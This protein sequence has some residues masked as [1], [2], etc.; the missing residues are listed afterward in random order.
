VYG[1]YAYATH[2]RSHTRVCYAYACMAASRSALSLILLNQS[3]GAQFAIFL[4]FR[5]F[6][7][8]TRPPPTHPPPPTHSQTVTP[9]PSSLLCLLLSLLLLLLGHL[10]PVCRRPSHFVVWLTLPPNPNLPPN[11]QAVCLAP[12]LFLPIFHTRRRRRHPPPPLYSTPP[13]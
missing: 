10:L 3:T 8:M 1:C 9:P 5:S 6:L 11:P 13:L 7:R 2:T 4:L 12:G